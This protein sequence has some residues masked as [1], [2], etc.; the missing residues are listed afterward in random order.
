METAL[1]IGGVVVAL[2]GLFQRRNI[3]R[4]C[5]ACSAQVGK[6]TKWV[7]GIDAIAIYQAEVDKSAEE[8]ESA[9]EGLEQYRSLISRLERQV[10]SGE[11]DELRLTL[12]VK[13]LL[14]TDE[15]R[16][17]EEAVHLNK[18]K[19]DLKEN[20]EQLNNYRDV[21]ENELKK[22]KFANDKIKR[23]RE[24]AEKM[25]AE[26]S[27]SRAEAE[28]A[29]LAK[30]FDMKNVNLDKLGEVENTI[31]NQIDANRAKGRVIRDLSQDG[32]DQLEEEETMQR[33]QA[34]SLIEQFKAEESQKQIAMQPQGVEIVINPNHVAEKHKL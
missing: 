5:S 32:L 7:Y 24:K 21:Y 22:I 27:L 30:Q 25:Q 12:R 11:K 18:V 29:K 1:V 8:I 14:S 4:L 28:T 9:G 2:F 19:V 13:T 33:A 3:G 6:V 34:Q 31:Q 23:A 17:T 26:L 15:R 16:A 10:T 20:R